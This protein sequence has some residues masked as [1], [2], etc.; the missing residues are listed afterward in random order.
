MQELGHSVVQI[1]DRPHHGRFRLLRRV[2][3]R[4][5]RPRLTA[6]AY[7]QPAFLALPWARTGFSAFFG[8]SLA[9]F[10]PLP[11]PEIGSNISRGPSGGFLP[12]AALGAGGA[13]AAGAAL[14]EAGAAALPA[15]ARLFFNAS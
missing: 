15:P 3:W 2:R 14:A 7:D 10:L 8:A 9:A 11:L 4:W 12:L 1:G 6:A 5:G 13:L